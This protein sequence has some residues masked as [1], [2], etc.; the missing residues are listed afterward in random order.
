MRD[1]VK[2]SN[3]KGSKKSDHL[4]A[5]TK[6]KKDK[7]KVESKSH[8][9]NVGT[10]VSRKRVISSLKIK[11]PR[12]DSSD[13]KLITGQKLPLKNKKSSQKPS[14][15][16]QGKKASLSSRKEGKDADG[17]VKLKKMKRKRKKKRQRNNLDLDDPSRLQRRTRYLL[18]KMKLEQ[19]LIDAYSGEGWKGQSREKIRPEKELQRARK[20]ILKC[21]LG[22][23]DAIRQLDSLGSL[24]SI[25]DS[26]IAPDGSGCHEHIFCAKCKVRE[27]PPDNDVIRC[28]GTCKRA[29]HQRCVDPPLDTE[30]VPPGRQ[31]WFCKFCECKMEIL[32]AMNAHLGTHFSL[33][34]AWQDVFKEEA[35]I[36]DGETAL[37]NPEEEWPSDDS[38]DDDYDP[39]RKEDSPNINMEGTNDSAS[40]DLSSSTSLCYSDDEYSPVDG[41]SHEY[42][43]VNSSIDSDESEDKACGR[44]QR[45]AVDYKQLYDEM[46]GKEAPA[47]EQLSEDEDWGPGKRKRREK[48]CDA[49]DSLMT[50]HESENKHPNNEQNNMTIKYSS[51]TNM[52]R[53]C[54][55]IPRDSVEKLR[56]VFAVNELPPRSIREDLS[57]E[58]GLDTE[59]VSKWFKNA[60]YLALKNRKH[61]AEGEANQLKRITSTKNS[62]LQ[63]QENTDLL[64]SK[65]LKITSH[66]EKDVK[67]VSG[68]KKIKFSSKKRPPEIP[69][70]PGENGNKDLM[71]IS[72]DV[73]LKKLLKKKKKRL[74][75]FTFEGDSQ[76]AE[77]EFERLCKLKQK[78]VSMKQKLTTIQSFRV[79]GSDEPHSNEPSIVY[80]PT[81]VLR[82]KFE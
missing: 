42:L 8:T 32:E 31:N 81:A 59:K 39:E 57:K 33:H 79:K 11:G 69:P 22:I 48:E 36:P 19:N 12:K 41:V 54:F 15:K 52:K 16:L 38:E 46:F 65:T 70:P 77:L 47:Y 21:R 82:E 50:L 28:Y 61:Q 30:N 73:S 17:E 20:Q 44:R 62:R 60:R 74:V 56:Q 66:S 1:S 9:K 49:V 4:K 26:A 27:E 67:N 35:A 2:K 40:D 24:S 64:K 29:F 25:E 63:N 51:S 3:D 45:K 6:G 71:E 13:K 68:R 10:D 34:S 7:V 75:S 76:T 23:R 58:L 80:V 55:R 78:L 5:R 72:D 43:F 14:L 18:I 53:H 37:L